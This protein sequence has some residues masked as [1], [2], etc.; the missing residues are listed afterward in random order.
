MKKAALAILNGANRIAAAI[1]VA[2]GFWGVVFFFKFGKV[3]RAS[4]GNWNRVL[5]LYGIMVAATL[6]LP[7][8]FM[9]TDRVK[10][11]HWRLVVQFLFCLWLTILVMAAIAIWLI[12]ID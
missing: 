1:L 3:W 6:I 4:E 10:S 11:P 2:A 5:G 7:P 9:W 8:L 12:A